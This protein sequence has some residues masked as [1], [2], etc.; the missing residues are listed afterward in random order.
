MKNFNNLVSKKIAGYF[1]TEEVYYVDTVNNLDFYE[2]VAFINSMP[3]L[4]FYENNWYLSHWY[5]L[6]L[7]FEIQKALGK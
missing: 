5:D 2:H 3:L 6:P 7:K 4:I 1:N